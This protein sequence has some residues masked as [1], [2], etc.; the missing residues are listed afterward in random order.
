M[1]ETTIKPAAKPSAKTSPAKP[2]PKPKPIAKPSIKHLEQPEPTV[3]E[4]V[5]AAPVKMAPTPMDLLSMAV[6]QDAPFEKLAT[7]MDLQERWEARE[8]RRAFVSALA[9]FKAD[10]PKLEKNKHVSYTT[11]KG[12]T[13]YKHA[14]LDS[15]TDV[16]NPALSRHG[17]SFRWDIQQGEKS[18]HVTCIL[19]HHL[20]HFENV[21]MSGSQ[22]ETGQKNALQ[23]MGSTVTY[24]MRYTLLAITGMSTSDQDTDAIPHSTVAPTFSPD[25]FQQHLAAIRAAKDLRELSAAFNA[26]YAKATSPSDK[27]DLI[28]AK[29]QRQR[30]LQK[31]GPK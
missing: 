21:T 11:S 10:P 4:L 28:E 9:A 23:Q 15:I 19:Q 8:A 13:S 2:T 16:L 22:D 3:L 31:D 20:G 14:T 18:I 1:S 27:S 24:L 29:N 17:L 6:A 5:T 12:Q 30:E 7:L 25:Q 26:A